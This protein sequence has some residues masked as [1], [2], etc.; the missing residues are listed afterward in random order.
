MK[1]KQLDFSSILNANSSLLNSKSADT[2]NQSLGFNRENIKQ[3]SVIAD[4]QKEA[5]GYQLAASKNQLVASTINNVL[6]GIAGFANAHK[7]VK[8]SYQTVEN[9]EATDFM[10]TLN[11]QYLTGLQ[12]LQSAG[13]I[14]QV[15]AEGN[16][17]VDFTDE[18]KSLVDGIKDQIADSKFSSFTKKDLESTFSS[19][20]ASNADGLISS[21]LQANVD[22]INTARTNSLNDTIRQS[23]INGDFSGVDTL[24][25]SWSD[26]S[27]QQ[28]ANIRHDAYD[29][30]KSGV[31]NEN[32]YARTRT[33]GYAGK[34]GAS[35]Y[36]DGLLAEGK[37]T[38]AEAASYR[39]TA[40]SVNKASLTQLTQSVTDTY[41]QSI[42]Q[43][44]T[45][46]QSRDAVMAIVNAAPE[47]MREDLKSSLDTLQTQQWAKID[48]KLADFTSM[49]SAEQNEYV[50]HLKEDPEGYFYGMD[51]QKASTL[52]TLEAQIDTTVTAEQ[53]QLQKAFDAEAKANDDMF[54]VG[55][56][57]GSKY[58]ENLQLMAQDDEYASLDPIY[59]TKT[60]VDKISK[61]RTSLTAESKA[62]VD[63]VLKVLDIDSKTWTSENASYDSVINGAYGKVLD[64]MMDYGTS[65]GSKDSMKAAAERIVTDYMG[66]ALEYFGKEESQAVIKT[67]VNDIKAGKVFE[68]AVQLEAL[69]AED[70]HYHITNSNVVLDTDADG[71]GV[72]VLG[73]T[74][75]QGEIKFTD[76][77]MEKTWQA[78]C[79]NVAFLLGKS[80]LN[81]E[82][83][84][85]ESADVM[86]KADGT[87]AQ[88]APSFASRDGSL[89]AIT[90]KDGDTGTVMKRTAAGGTWKAVGTVKSDGSFHAIDEK[91]QSDKRQDEL[92]SAASKAPASSA[93]SASGLSDVENKIY[94]ALEEGFAQDGKP[95]EQDIEDAKLMVQEYQ[96]RY[97]SVL[98]ASDVND[99]FKDGQAFKR[100]LEWRSKKR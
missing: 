100:Y 10:V 5:I 25:A 80:V 23:V 83:L 88:L 14:F 20:M 96:E 77:N 35:E 7:T 91:Q 8:Q 85:P 70:L 44:M 15:D 95:T 24:I 1:I 66:E 42:Q 72:A 2:A 48:T 60:I 33:Q 58:V 29:S 67:G 47:E 50:A 63:G 3:Q 17:T 38:E 51:A 64:M 75:D 94:K 30:Y 71:K 16:T 81:G 34:G 59:V 46:V 74:Q 73:G 57:S 49:N 45:M 99:F 12:G 53:A 36:I 21:Q 9:A 84:L 22:A 76:P 87:V 90:S 78:Q 11:K 31:I 43:G 68:T 32:I 62:I 41:A 55:I 86:R 37:I 19:N 89:Y 79:N 13:K 56:I 97:S 69:G 39:S 26:M 98:S 54:S 93:S 28:Q 65:E 82:E 52:K 27:K 92:N 18:Y 6:D 40:V 61:A 4:K